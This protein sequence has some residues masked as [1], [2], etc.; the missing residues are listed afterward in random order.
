MNQQKSN[1]RSGCCIRLTLVLVSHAAACTH[2]DTA[3]PCDQYV[4]D[5][6]PRH[7]CEMEYHPETAAYTCSTVECSLYND[8]Q[9][10]CNIGYRVQGG[11]DWTPNYDICTPSGEYA[12]NDGHS[13]RHP[14]ILTRPLLCP[15]NAISSGRPL[16]LQANR[17]RAQPMI[18][19]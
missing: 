13:S 17:S 6:C 8:N 16:I 1:L 19:W 14:S 10:A 4:E 11:C 15:R 3:L 2:L 18:S 12:A 7:R 5:D 9:T